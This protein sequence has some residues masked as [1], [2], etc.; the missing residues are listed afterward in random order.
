MV[1]IRMRTLCR[2]APALLISL[3]LAGCGGG[4]STGGPGTGSLRVE[5]APDSPGVVSHITVADQADARTFEFDV[6]LAPGDDF[7]VR[8]LLS[9]VY[10]LT[11]EWDDGHINEYMDITVTE[12]NTTERE[13]SR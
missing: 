4:G 10:D 5:H 3:S 12:G 9:G 13:V 6:T 11:V 7:T 8:E 1:F 2:L